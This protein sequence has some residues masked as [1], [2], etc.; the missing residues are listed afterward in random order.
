MLVTE[1]AFTES[2]VGVCVLWPVERRRQRVLPGQGW[3]SSS[4]T[5]QTL[6]QTA[7]S[8]CP[9][10]P[11][12]GSSTCTHKQ[13][14]V[15]SG[16]KLCTIYILLI[17]LTSDI[18]VNV[19]LFIFT[20]YWMLGSTTSYLRFTKSDQPSMTNHIYQTNSR[21]FKPGCQSLTCWRWCRGSMP[22]GSCPAACLSAW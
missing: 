6:L 5:L 18:I 10:S 11:A 7:Q 4:E 22:S 14:L 17:K 9:H 12:T 8:C 21:L 20:T 2:M 16:I 3:W 15:R 1:E 19:W 13:G